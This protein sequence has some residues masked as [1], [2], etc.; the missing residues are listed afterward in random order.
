MPEAPMPLT[1]EEAA[2]LYEKYGFFLLRRCRT[3]LRDTASADDALQ[4]AF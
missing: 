2:L 4:Q 3:L 1:P